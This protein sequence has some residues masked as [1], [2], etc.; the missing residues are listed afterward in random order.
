MATDT[1]LIARAALAH[2]RSAGATEPDLTRSRVITGPT[3]TRY[4]ALANSSGTPLVVYRYDPSGSQ[5]R[6]L[7]GIP[8]PVRTAYADPDAAAA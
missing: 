3:G 2:L 7:K 1:E 4:A 8:S 5:L 6:A